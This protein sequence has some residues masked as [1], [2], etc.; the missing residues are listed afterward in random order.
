[1]TKPIDSVDDLIKALGGEAAAAK[2]MGTSKTYVYQF[3]R[4]NQIPI[5]YAKAILDALGPDYDMPVGLFN[6]QGR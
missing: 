4:A 5:K 2:V 3:K 6:Y 1:V